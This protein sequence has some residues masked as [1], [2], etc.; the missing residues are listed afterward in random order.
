MPDPD[1]P[2]GNSWYARLGV[3]PLVN[4]AGRYTK[5]GGSVMPPAVVAAMADAARCHVPIDDLQRKSGERLAEL[6]RNE[7]AYVT[8]GAAAGIVLSI[9]V[10]ATG[11]DPVAV[12]AV[13]EGR[14]RPREVIVQRGHHVP[15]VPAVRLAGARV[16]EVGTLM[17]T[18]P[19]DFAAAVGEHTVAVLHIA[20]DHLA[21]GTL[22]LASVRQAVGEVPVIV[23]AAAQLP[24]VEN[25]WRFTGEGGGDV[26]LFSGGK[27]LC[28]P[29]ASGLVVG[30]SS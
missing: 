21:R 29:Q 5:F 4:A 23:D 1:L 17:G 3:R 28:G 26:A 11:T 27:D 14:H 7:A 30:R 19:A 13:A 10:A 9:L 12:R 16:V 22:D 18:D 8:T 24:P 6:T 2:A 15:Y 25:L 20:G